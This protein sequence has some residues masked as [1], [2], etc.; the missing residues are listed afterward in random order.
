MRVS[1]AS[2]WFRATESLGDFIGIRFGRMAADSGE[3]EWLHVSHVECDGIGAFARLLRERGADLPQLPLTRHPH[4]GVLRPILEL[5]LSGAREPRRAQRADW[6]PPGGAR[7]GQPDDVAWHL[8]SAEETRELLAACRR[9]KITVNSL[10][11]KC[12]DEAVRPELGITDASIPWMIPVNLRGDV[13]LPDDTENHVS[14]FDALVDPRMS[15]QDLQRQIHERLERG[16]HRANYLLMELGRHLSHRIKMYLLERVRSRPH[17]NIGSFSN[18]GVWDAEKRIA[19]RDAWWFCPPIVCG[20]RL[21]AGCV[22]FQNRLSLTLQTH[23]DPTADS[24][25]SRTCMRRWVD[26]ISLIQSLA[27]ELPDP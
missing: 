10:L 2:L 25:L 1:T 4:R 26:R 7:H 6:L 3:V 24:S 9:Q 18:L 15:A 20:Q 11:L 14:C 5:C 8:F 19:N 16:E 12:L 23:G 22:T 27:S 21:S 13:T 17:G